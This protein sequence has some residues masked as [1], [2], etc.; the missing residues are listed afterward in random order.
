MARQHLQKTVG[1]MISDRIIT[2]ARHELYLSDKP[3]KQIADELGFHDVAYFS[4]FF[5]Q[6]TALSPDSYRKSFRQDTA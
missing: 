2:Q 5:K 3:V 4:R 1:E 6:R